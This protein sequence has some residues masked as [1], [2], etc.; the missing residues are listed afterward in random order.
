MKR[1]ATGAALGGL[2]VYLYDP[3]LGEQ[4][5]ERL[6]SLWRENR[7][8]AVQAGRTAS[9]VAESARPLARR[10]T[11]A[12]R[13]GDWTEALDHSRPAARLPWIIGAVAVGGA[14]VY[15]LA[16]VKGAERR[17][18]FLSAWQVKGRSALDA[19][20]SAARQTAEAVKPVVGRV[21]DQVSDAVD[22]VKSM[23]G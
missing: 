16:P 23:V 13:R 1:L 21:S 22:G 3:A 10:M 18:R 2:A 9:Q 12:V 8:T 20:R 7:H 11:N 6:F 5:R 19:G 17:Q 15:F 4:R 14:L